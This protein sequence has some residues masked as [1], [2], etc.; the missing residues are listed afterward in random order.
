LR[1]GTKLTLYLSLIIIVVLSGYGYFHILTRRDILIRK[2]EVEVGS[3]GQTLK[4]SLEKISLSKEPGYVQDLIDAVE[5]H[6][7]TLGLIV[8]DQKEDRVF[9]SNSLKEGIEP[10]LELIK[11]SIRENRTQEQ[12]GKYK[13]MPVFSYAFPLKDK[14]GKIYGGV[15][16]LQQTTFMEQDIRRA[17]W[18]IFIVILVL[19]GG[20]VALVA[21]LTRRWITYPI[22]QLMVGIDRLAKGNLNTRIDVKSGDELSELAK[23]FNQMAVDLRE[24]QK[25]I[26]QEAETKLELE[27]SL[28][29]SEK[30]AIIGQ[31]ASG[32]AHEI[33]TPLNI[34]GGRAELMQRRLD[35]KEASQKNLDIIV[36]QTERITKI[37][38]QLLGFVRKK[39]PEQK[40]LKIS[41]L[42]ETT[43]DFL[44]HQIQKQEVNVVREIGDH[45][46]PV[47]GDPDQLQ[48]VFLN[49]ILNAVQ[50]MPK[51]GI[52]R[53]SASSE[54]ISKEGLEN[55]QQPYVVVSVIDTGFGMEKEVVQNVFNPFFTTKDTGTGLGLMVSQGIVQDHE[56]WI[57]VESELGKGSTFKVYLPA[58][59]GEVKSE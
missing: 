16:I 28:R 13:K 33:G 37:I 32:L 1:L 44:D 24:A 59:H 25:R 45:L 3:I 8:Y 46:P 42:L 49:L 4:V 6:E 55:R 35:D 20:T 34:I 10:Y 14:R 36:Q 7:K 11:N 21:F 2:M 26:I 40:T 51:G 50:S 48:Q 18:T 23:A 53:L 52:L 22:S 58:L 43:I 31:L 30:L 12:F 54:W 9:R 38:Q 29:Q 47:M 15:T 56:G 39:K 27:R 19:I 5:E 41:T 57:D 17:K